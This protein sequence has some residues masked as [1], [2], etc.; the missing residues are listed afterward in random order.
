MDRSIPLAVALLATA[1][2][3]RPTPR[4]HEVTG[5]VTTDLPGSSGASAVRLDKEG[6]M[7]VAGVFENTF[8]LAGT[9][10]KSYGRHDIFLAKFD[11][12]Y[13]LLWLEAFGGP[14]ND[15][16]PD[17]A[18]AD[19][20]SVTLCCDFENMLNLSQRFALYADGHGQALIH[21]GADGSGKEVWEVDAK[22]GVHEVQVNALTATGS[23]VRGIGNFTADTLFLRSFTLDGTEKGRMFMLPDGSA[24]LF[25]F[26][27]KYNGAPLLRTFHADGSVYA[28]SNRI[29]ALSDGSVALCGTHRGSLRFGDHD[30]SGDGAYIAVL[31]PDLDPVRAV[32]L[33]LTCSD[34]AALSLDGLCTDDAGDAWALLGFK[35]NVRSHELDQQWD[36]GAGK[37]A[38]L[39]H[40]DGNG[41]V[42]GAM[43]FGNSDDLFTK[44]VAFDPAQ[45]TLVVAGY[46]HGPLN[47]TEKIQLQ[48]G[49]KYNAFVV[50]LDKDL[51]IRTLD[52]TSGA[53]Q[54]FLLAMDA[55]AG[56]VAVAGTYFQAGI[57]GPFELPQ[58]GGRFFAGTMNASQP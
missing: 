6:N 3:T 28:L 46:H 40:L 24:T 33:K 8:T 2:C 39:L 34:P 21:V 52:H 54:Q 17:V 30:A 29:S 45:G 23:D 16:P 32:Q 49:G 31:G 14:G 25:A 7:I 55:K 26:A 53:G 20:G 5:V 42:R 4:A 38:L 13:H 56:H 12:Q 19:D 9:T 35:D 22:G 44:G 47:V 15:F 1:A 51:G 58:P 37:D 18:V 57:I 10:L 43:R 41:G 11:P 36:A 27:L 48:G 50:G